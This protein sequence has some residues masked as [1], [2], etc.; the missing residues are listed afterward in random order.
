MLIFTCSVCGSTNVESKCWANPNTD[1]IS[2]YLGDDIQDNW[3]GECQEHQTLD[4]EETTIAP[5]DRII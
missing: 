4:Y 5:E 2:E 1:K 3:C